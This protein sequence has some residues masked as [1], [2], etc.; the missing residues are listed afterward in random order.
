M[1]GG[2]GM[3]GGGLLHS[4]HEL[5]LSAAQKQQLHDILSKTREQFEARKPGGAPDM[6]ALANPGDPNYAAAVQAAKKRAAD[7]IQKASD[8]KLQL[9]NVL[10]PDQK[11]QLSKQMAAWKARMAERMAQRADGAKGPPAPANR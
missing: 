10:T 2:E 9:Y 1:M 5:N 3:A 8:L 7:R 11:A 4:F 6:L